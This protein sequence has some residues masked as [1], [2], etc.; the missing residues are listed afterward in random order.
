VPQKRFDNLL[1]AFAQI[2]HEDATLTILGDGSQRKSLESLAHALGIAERVYLPGYVGDIL[3]SLRQTDLFV[4]SSDYEGLPAVIFEA[5]ASNVPVITT[6]SF[7]AARELLG[8]VEWCA[9]VPI[10]N[11]QALAQG[12]DGCLASP[13]HGA[14]LR[15]LAE[16]YRG[17]PAIEAHVGALVRAVDALA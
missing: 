9:V 17:K 15:K 11:P 12:I 7:F 10:G 4:L 8:D 1:R 2:S 14:D 6:E 3:P 13:L 16:P 5:L